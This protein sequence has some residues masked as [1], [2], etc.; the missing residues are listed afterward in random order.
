[1]K[2][3]HDLLKALAEKREG[4]GVLL[5][6]EVKGLLRGLGI[7]VP[8]GIFVS[9]VQADRLSK[10]VNIPYP[11]VAK[12]SSSTIISKSEVKGV[13]LGIKNEDELK[14]SAAELL[15]L[16]GA[17]GVL[18][19]QMQPKGLEVITGGIIDEQFGPVVMFGLGGVFV[20]LFKDVSF[21]LAP[22]KREDA[23]WLIKQIKGYRL[24]EGYRGE[25][26]VDIDSLVNILVTVSELISSGFVKEIDLNP[27]ALYPGGAVVLDA[28]V[29]LAP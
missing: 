13:R 17:E 19:E 12:V 16:N 27:V 29:S 21:A 1:M 28:K 14:K 6:H 11:L 3:Q 4:N 15:D 2:V 9:K 8:E 26:P 24:L 5:E 7:A 18:I 25:P 23:L 10:L 20:E 22:L